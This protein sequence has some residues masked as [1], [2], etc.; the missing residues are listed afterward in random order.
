M[1]SVFMIVVHVVREESF[2]M[3]FVQRDSVVEEFTS[4]TPDPALG[5]SVLPWTLDGG[6]H[7]SHLHRSHCQRNFQTVLLVVVKDEKPRSSLIGERFAQLLD[8]PEACRMA[9]D[10]HIKRKDVK[11]AHSPNSGAS[12][13]S[14]SLNVYAETRYGF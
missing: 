13:I 5:H 9:S 3:A 14:A 2:Q 10:R 8:N 7:S 6:L 12:E 1:S 11:L 4:A